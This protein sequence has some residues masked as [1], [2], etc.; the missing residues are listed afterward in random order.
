MIFANLV[1]F[2]KMTKQ[3]I[4]ILYYDLYRISRILVFHAKVQGAR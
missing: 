1:I 3:S 2:F 4:R